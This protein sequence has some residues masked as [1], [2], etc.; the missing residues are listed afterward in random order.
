MDFQKRIKKQLSSKRYEHSVRVAETAVKLAR[1]HGCDEEKAEIAGLLHDYC[2]E[3]PKEE[4]V[5]IAVEQHLLSSREDLLMPQ[6]L[7]GPVASYILKQEGLVDDESVLQA[8]RY[9]TT[10][11]PDMDTLAKIIFIADYIEPGR[12]TPNI[13]DLFDIAA[14]D[15]DECVVEIVD[16]TTVYLIGKRQ[17]IHGDMIKLRNRILSKE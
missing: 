10:G 14:R 2:K 13:D 5:R 8:V 7:H 15:L 9:H 1:L 4:Q 16:R 11:H 17:I 12:K 3:Y 6:V